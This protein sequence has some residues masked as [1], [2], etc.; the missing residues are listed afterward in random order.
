MTQV[1]SGA[2]AAE[3]GLTPPSSGQTQGRFAPLGLPL[4]S[5][6]RQHL[7]HSHAMVIGGTGML[8]RASIAIAESAQ[9]FTAVARRSESLNSLA[10]ALGSP[11]KIAM[12]YLALDWNRPT[13]FLAALS[14]HVEQV[15]PPSFVL[16]WLH[17]INLG[18]RVACAAPWLPTGC[19]SD[20]DLRRRQLAP[21]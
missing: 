18:P 11:K 10:Q 6:V 4:M 21:R 13:E 17:D 9:V 5:N 14:R 12:Y 19:C 1:R 16:A 7:V 2:G 8:R 3:R 20:R 15:G